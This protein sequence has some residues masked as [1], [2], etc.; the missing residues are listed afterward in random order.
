MAEEEGTTFPAARE[1]LGIPRLE[2][3]GREM[4]DLKTQLGP[5][6]AAAVA[7]AA[8]AVKRVVRGPA[9]G[10]GRVKALGARSE[11]IVL[12]KALGDEAVAFLVP[13]H[14]AGDE[15]P[16]EHLGGAEPSR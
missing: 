8:R 13:V 11:L 9:R 14:V 2:E 16:L 3:L 1:F 4:A 12:E 6:I 5:D 15:V 10:R 7:S